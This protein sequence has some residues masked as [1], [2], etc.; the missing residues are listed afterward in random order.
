MK[1]VTIVMLTYNAE[2][3]VEHSIRTIKNIQKVIV[4][5]IDTDC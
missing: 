1:K 5:V 3:Y 4:K 2:K